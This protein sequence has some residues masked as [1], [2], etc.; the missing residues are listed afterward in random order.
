MKPQSP[1]HCPHRLRR[2]TTLAYRLD[3]TIVFSPPWLALSLLLALLGLGACSNAANGQGVAGDAVSEG[4]DIPNFLTD[5]SGTETN[6]AADLLSSDAPSDDAALDAAVGPEVDVGTG[7]TAI[8]DGTAADAGC[9]AAGCACTD[10]SQC[11]NNFCVEIDGGKQC[12]A[13]CGA[14]C[15]SGLKCASLAGNGGDI[16]NVCVPAFPRICEPCQADSDCNNV[17]G[18]SDSR[19]VPYAD[20]SGAQLGAFCGAV[21]AGDNNCPDGYLCKAGTSVG[22][23]TSSQCVRKD[24]VCAC[25]ARATTLQLG[26]SCSSVNGAGTCSGKRSCGKDGLSACNAAQAKAEACNLID[27]DCDGQT[28]ELT[29][30]LCDDNLQCT[31]DNCVSGQ[32]QHP[33]KTGACDDASTCTTGD[34]CSDGDCVGVAVQCDDKNPC[35]TDSCDATKGCTTSAA[36]GVDCSDNNACTVGDACSG[37]QCLPGDATVCDDGNPCTTDSCNS[38]TG[39][40]FAAN[41]LAC[42]D[43]NLCTTT[44]TC[45]GGVCV[46]GATLPC[47]DGNPCSDDSCDPKQGCVFAPNTSSCSDG[48]VCTQDDTCVGGQCQ[49]GVAKVCDDINPCTTDSCDAKKGCI[50]AVNSAPCTDNNPCTEGDLCKVGVCQGGPAKLCDDGNPCTTDSCDA[51]KGCVQAPNQASCDDGNTCTTGDVCTGGTCKPGKVSVCDDKDPCTTDSCD[52]TIGCTST[53]NTAPCDDG[54]VCT[55]GDVCAGGQCQ[56]GKLVGCDDGNACTDDGCD[57]QKGCQHAANAGVCSDGNVCT[58][59]DSCQG[60]WCMP[61]GPKTCDDGNPCTSDFCDAIK[62]CQ[63]TDNVL[64]CDD[65]NPCTDSDLCKSGFCNPGSP[66]VCADGNPCTADS[67]D[68]KKGC[69][70]TVITPA[71]D[72]GN[73]CTL[74]DQCQGGFCLPT[75]I[76]S[77]N[78]NNVCTTDS[79]DAVKGCQHANVGGVCNDGN[80]CTGGDACMGGACVAAPVSCDD[81][82]ACTIDTCDSKTGCAHANVAD[83]VACGANQWCKTGQCVNKAFCGDGIVNQANEQCDDGNAIAGDGCEPDCTLTPGK[84]CTN[85]SFVD[86]NPAGQT[87]IPSSA[88]VDANPPAGW[89]QCAG[90]VNT[91]GDDIGNTALDNCLNTTRLRVKVWDSNGVLEEDV[92][93]EDLAQTNAWASWNYLGGTMTKVKSTYWTGSTTYFTTTNG[94][95]AC[96]V[97]GCTAAPCNTLTL[98]TGNGSSAIVAPGNTNALEWRVNCGGAALTGRKVALYK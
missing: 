36:V 33:P 43:G 49:P 18:G 30:G 42:S 10:N 58:V 39:C 25:D 65:G 11:D 62:G 71:C 28:D 8:A 31:Y 91:A 81:N 87:L 29:P 73:Q 19:C 70:F 53:P 54:S 14:G 89:T 64:P 66:K 75:S 68:S 97:N 12:A 98:G 78:D 51:I 2:A 57:A 47:Q 15:G 38:K 17:L 77:C 24:L 48:N 95:D 76:A 13:L 85:G 27:D 5:A 56:P 90:F 37:G 7:E 20:A 44:D 67:C 22:G 82:N 21:C 80:A 88:F 69:I 93:S 96:A 59:L 63:A 84:K 32:C 23:V 74:G 83:Q 86:C 34:K 60:G 45:S 41:G 26:T 50:Y 61:G 4:N 16:V 52:P 3:R 72:D 94:T 79:C 1:S 6:L 35:T 55:L 9:T 92:Y 46:P 40:I